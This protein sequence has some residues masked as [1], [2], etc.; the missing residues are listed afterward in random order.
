LATRGHHETALAAFQRTVALEPGHLD[1]LNTMGN[2]L[3]ALDRHE[4]AIACFRQALAINPNYPP[5]LYNLGRRLSELG[6]LDEAIEILRKALVCAGPKADPARLTDIHS[7]LGRAQMEL[8]RSEEALAATRAMLALNSDPDRARWCASLVQLA[9]GQ[10]AEGWENYEFRYAIEEQE[11]PQRRGCVVNPGSIS[12]KHI[13]VCSEQGFGD[14]IQFAR[15]VKLLLQAGASVSLAVAPELESLLREID[16]VTEVVPLGE[17]EPTH[18]LTTVFPSLPLAFH[19]EVATIPADV[20][21]LRAP[22][23]RVDAWREKLG[24]ARK[25]RVGICSW[26]SQHIPTRSMPVAALESILDRSD[27]EFHILQKDVSAPDREWL[28]AHPAIHVHADALNDFA[29]TAAL[30]MQ[31]DLTIS[32]DTGVA[33]LAGALGRPVWIMLGFGADWRWLLNRDDSPWYPTARLFRQSRPRDWPSAIGRVTQA[34]AEY[35]FTD[36]QTR[37]DASAKNDRPIAPESTSS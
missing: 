29:D 6:R 33:H 23:D 10:Y 13:L 12:G 20:P 9:L 25:P 18:D 35:A 36:L 14:T 2:T 15:Y 1:A 28:A 22:A 30:I 5:A 34:L 16:G 19:T 27:L 4:D 37:D 11:P 7:E 24:P 31:M 3:A 26:G 8:G 17:R 32:I 21:Y